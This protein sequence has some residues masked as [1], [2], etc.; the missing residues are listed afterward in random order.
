M[1][2]YHGSAELISTLKDGILTLKINRPHKRNALNGETSAKMEEILNLAESDTE[3]RV[4]IVTGEGEK[5]FCAGEDLS[6]LSESGECQTITAHGF[7]GLTNRLSTKP[8]IAA[9]NGV[10]V[11]GGMEIALACDIVIACE[12]ARFGLPEVK[13]GLIASTGGLVRMGRELPRKVAMQMC[14]T[15]ELINAQRAK[16]IGI[17]N[18]VVS[19]ESLIPRAVE[20][21]GVIAKNAPLSLKFTKQIIHQSGSMSLEDAM[22]LSD[23]A[24]RYIEKTEDGVEGPLAFMQKREPK[25]KGK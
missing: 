20:L 8:I 1:K 24:Y 10:A 18:E 23:I 3:V 25:W 11:G 14:L 21:A 7:G 13:V 4:I 16:E 6:E 15:G 2:D 17:I 12:G 5:S 22:R 19:S 9:V